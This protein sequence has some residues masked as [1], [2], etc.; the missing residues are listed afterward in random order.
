MKVRTH[1]TL[2]RTKYVKCFR[3]ETSSYRL[4]FR[5]KFIVTLE[6]LYNQAES[7]FVQCQ[8]KLRAFLSAVNLNKLNSIEL[9]IKMLYGVWSPLQP[10]HDA[11]KSPRSMPV[12]PPARN[13]DRSPIWKQK[14]LKT[15]DIF[16]LPRIS[17]KDFPYINGKIDRSIGINYSS[18]NFKWTQ[19]FLCYQSFDTLG[20]RN[21][22][23]AVSGFGQ[24]SQRSMNFLKIQV[25]QDKS[26]PTR[27]AM[28]WLRVK[29]NRTR[30]CTAAHFARNE[31]KYQYDPGC[32]I[33]CL[34]FIP[35]YKQKFYKC[36]SLSPS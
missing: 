10:D 35:L 31:I 17:T 27:V 1:S 6:L 24:V 33:A 21:F 19:V 18:V 32:T 16:S 25:I 23:C 20:A 26:K 34:S 36:Y 3:V 11:N 13:D 5:L 22:S 29:V 4:V 8:T 14:H 9:F 30:L 2:S 28:I 7:D 12:S 15:S